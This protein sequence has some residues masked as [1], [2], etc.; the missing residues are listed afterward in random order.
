M[1]C[2]WQ[3]LFS[4]VYSATCLITGRRVALKLYR[5]EQMGP[6]QVTMIRRQVDNWSTARHRHLVDFYAA[7]Q[8]ESCVY[9][10]MELATGV[11][12]GPADVSYEPN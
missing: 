6:R 1:A 8:D 4:D 3:G 5:K 12:L 9:I 10:V 11:R 2:R 7:F